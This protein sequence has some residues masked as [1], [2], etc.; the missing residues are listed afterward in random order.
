MVDGGG[1][2]GYLHVTTEYV[3]SASTFGAPSETAKFVSQVAL[4][5]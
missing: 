3:K 2:W 1:L 5:G 4:V